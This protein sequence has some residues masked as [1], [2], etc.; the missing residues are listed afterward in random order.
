MPIARLRNDTVPILKGKKF[1]TLKKEGS[2]SNQ[3]DLGAG[4]QLHTPH[5]L[6]NDL[7]AQE[8]QVYTKSVV[9]YSPLPNPRQ[10]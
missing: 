8:K 10:V 7:P 9:E 4:V 5:V 2:V 3:N 6:R 1:L